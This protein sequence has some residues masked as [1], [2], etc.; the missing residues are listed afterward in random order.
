[1]HRLTLKFG[2]AVSYFNITFQH[3]N[4]YEVPNTEDDEATE[5]NNELMRR[6]HEDSHEVL[7]YNDGL[8]TK[9]RKKIREGIDSQINQP[10][11]SNPIK[12]S[13]RA[14]ERNNHRQDK[15]NRRQN[16]PKQRRS[17][18]IVGDS[19]IKYLSPMKVRRNSGV[20]VQVKTFLGTRLEEMTDYVK[21]TMKSPPACVVFTCRKKRC[22]IQV[23]TKNLCAY[24][25][26]W[27]RSYGYKS[28]Y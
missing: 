15:L 21:P 20:K 10:N 5:N 25:F 26:I 13:Q 1:M 17:V 12:Q 27:K 6:C 16:L 14:E 18:T 9:N 22:K 28:K 19:M 7:E 3:Q 2:K 23:F 11:S 4:K 8:M 24:I